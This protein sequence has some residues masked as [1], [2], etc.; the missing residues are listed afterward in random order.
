MA[1]QIGFRLKWVGAPASE[2]P[3]MVNCCA[4]HV[5]QGT[6]Y[7]DFG[8]LDPR[9]IVATAEGVRAVGKP[10]EELETKH[11]LRVAMS[12]ETMEQ[13]RSQVDELSSRVGGGKSGEPK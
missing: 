10:P 1:E 9:V 11:V 3:V 12:P 2:T 5:A 7:I 6:W 13:L 4:V 8:F